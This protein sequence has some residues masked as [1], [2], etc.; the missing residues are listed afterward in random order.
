MKL[1]PPWN[2][3]GV[4]DGSGIIAREGGVDTHNEGGESDEEVKRPHFAEID[5]NAYRVRQSKLKIAIAR[6]RELV[7]WMD[8]GSRNLVI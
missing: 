7:L 8:A 1:I 2:D 3:E 6:L 5:I 4:K